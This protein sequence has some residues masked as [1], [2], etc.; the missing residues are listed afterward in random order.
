VIDATEVITVLH[1]KHD[2]SHSPYGERDRVG[3]PEEEKSLKL[4]GGLSH[5]L[6]L[7]D[8]DWILIS[9]GLKR[10]KFPRIIFS[11]LSL[12]YP[13]RLILAIKRRLFS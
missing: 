2:Y 1:Q 11:K 6:T 4:A 10:P 9:Q 7:R 8:A 3:G 5:M 13:W 12:F